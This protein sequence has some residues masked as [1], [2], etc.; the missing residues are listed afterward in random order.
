MSR[1]DEIE[2]DEGVAQDICPICE[3][4][5]GECDHLVASIDRTFS[6]LTAG[7]IFAHER[8][9]LDLLERLAAREPDLLKAA[10]A[11][12]E[13]E[14]VATIVAAEMGEGLSAGDAVSM[15]LPLILAALGCML[16]EQG[17]VTITDVDAAPGE[18]SSRENFWAEES[19]RVVEGLIA[20]LQEIADDSEDPER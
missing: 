16:Q 5:E 19:E 6:E 3:S 15:H 14:N 13:L 17:D 20:R 7:A 10:G 8:V 1:P 9:V 2:D 18:G 11:G 4:R 12:P